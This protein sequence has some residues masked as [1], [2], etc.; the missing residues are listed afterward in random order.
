MSSLARFP[1]PPQMPTVIADPQGKIILVNAQTEPIF[2]YKREELLG[3]PVEMLI[4]AR[5]HVLFDEDVAFI[6]K[7]FTHDALGWKIRQM[8]E[9]RA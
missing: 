6:E 1:K 4:P 7:P 8:L 2:G 3:Q 5:Y 9:L